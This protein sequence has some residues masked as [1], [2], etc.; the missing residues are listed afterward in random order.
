MLLQKGERRARAAARLISFCGGRR[1]ACAKKHRM[2]DTIPILA[3]FAF[4]AFAIAYV[5][6]C[7]RL[8]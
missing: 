6:A 4:F 1:T 2:L 7:E 8:K 3:S 5:R